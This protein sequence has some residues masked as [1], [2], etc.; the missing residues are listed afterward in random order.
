MLR[1]VSESVARL[2]YWTYNAWVI[3]PVTEVVVF[4]TSASYPRE[5]ATNRGTLNP[6]WQFFA[7]YIFNIELLES[8]FC[9]KTL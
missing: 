6:F 3:L 5:L 9:S 4:V 2:L 8:I 1:A 7:V